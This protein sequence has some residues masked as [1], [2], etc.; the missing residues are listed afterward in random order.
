MVETNTANDGTQ[1]YHE[2]S[3]RGAAQYNGQWTTYH[4]RGDNL[5]YTRRR[6][7]KNH[8]FWRHFHEFRSRT[9]IKYSF[10]HHVSLW[11]LFCNFEYYKLIDPHTM[12]NHHQKENYAPLRDVD[13]HKHLKTR[14]WNS[15]LAFSVVINF[16]VV[17]LNYEYLRRSLKVPN[18]N[19]EL[20]GFFSHFATL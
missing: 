12:I 11:L 6:N 4:N 17:F 7:L 16:Y 20:Q 19:S 18:W 13:M 9:W 15:N 2:N 14:N 1:I 5:M 3:N 10:K 8:C